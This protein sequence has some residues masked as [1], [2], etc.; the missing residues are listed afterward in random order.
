MCR[1]AT[2][3]VVGCP[4]WILPFANAADPAY[5]GTPDA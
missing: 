1:T 4:E 2:F 3:A 5:W